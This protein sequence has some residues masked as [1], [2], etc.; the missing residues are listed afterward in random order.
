M[1]G[2]KTKV[3]G[4]NTKGRSDDYGLEAISSTS[5]IILHAPLTKESISHD[6]HNDQNWGGH[7]KILIVDDDGNERVEYG[8]AEE[9]D[10]E[11]DY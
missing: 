5:K 11:D 3:T 9:D 10:E 8:G 2:E 4:N 1:S 6:N 7:G